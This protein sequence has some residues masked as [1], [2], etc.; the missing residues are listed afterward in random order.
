MYREIYPQRRILTRIQALAQGVGPTPP[1][2]HFLPIFFIYSP[3]SHVCQ[4][5]INPSVLAEIK[6]HVSAWFLFPTWNTDRSNG[7]AVTCNPTRILI[8]QQ[9]SFFQFYQQTSKSCQKIASL[10]NLLVPKLLFIL[11]RQINLIVNNLM[12]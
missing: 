12:L 1:K 11:A 10:V 6:S 2:F 5:S 7:T 8:L 9:N 4:D 3:I